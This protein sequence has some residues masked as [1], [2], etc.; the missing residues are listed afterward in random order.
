[1]SDTLEVLGPTIGAIALSILSCVGC[2]FGIRRC[3]RRREFEAQM[4]ANQA[5]PPQPPIQV[6]TYPGA[7]QQY[8]MSYSQPLAPVGYYPY[9]QQPSAYYPYPQPSAPMGPVQV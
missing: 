2:V 1:M 3:R 4:A 8:V 7:Q 5:I 9:Q 6:A